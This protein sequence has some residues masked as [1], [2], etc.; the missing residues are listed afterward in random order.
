[1]R[2]GANR[3]E[4]RLPRARENVG[5]EIAEAVDAE[6]VHHLDQPAAADV[7]AGG[8]RIE[9]ADDLRRLAH[10]AGDDGDQRLVDD[11]RLRE[12]HQR[13][14]EALFVDLP[15]L[16]PHAAPADIDDMTRTREKRHGL[17]VP[18]GRRHHREVVEMARTL[19]R[20]VGYENVARRHGGK[21]KRVQKMRDG[22]GHGID[23]AG[24]ARHR[25]REHGAL[26]V[27][28]AGREIARLTH[29]GAEGRA[30]QHLRLFLD[31][32]DQPVPHDLA[33]QEGERIRRVHARPSRVMTMWR[34]PL[35]RA[36]KPGSTTVDVSSSTITAGPGTTAPGRRTARS[37][38]AVSTGTPRAGSTMARWVLGAGLCSAGGNGRGPGSSTA[39]DRRSDQFSTSAPRLGMERPNKEV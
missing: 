33:M 30:D 9:I 24:R 2:Q 15:P 12:A 16:R 25:L 5:T 35:M 27:E 22:A 4:R 17:A 18:E 8:E 20:I 39:V 34:A 6:F 7:V 36:T 19:P 29:G 32:G 11:A 21:G 28:H 31:D 38:S 26:H 10:V 14:V 3:L 1:M 37:Y 13:H 23:V